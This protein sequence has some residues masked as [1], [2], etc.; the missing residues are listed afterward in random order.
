[1]SESA[2]DLGAGIDAQPP[3]VL[4]VDDFDDALDIY[5]EYLT[6]KGIH[7]IT[8]SSGAECLVLARQY[9]PALI[10]LDIRMAL[11]SGTETMQILRADSRFSATPIVAL[12]SQALEDEHVTAL[13]AGF[14]EVISKPCNP[15]DLVSAVERLIAAPRARA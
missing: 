13:A 3:V 5:R 9:Q 12:T 8:A 15:D 7:V 11:M 10:F 4:I 6:F 14:N 1:M 2:A